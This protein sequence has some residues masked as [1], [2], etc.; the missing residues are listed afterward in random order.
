MRTRARSAR[1]Q[2]QAV[3]LLLVVFR[4]AKARGPLHTFAEQRA[5][6]SPRH[7]FAEQKATISFLSPHQAA[8]ESSDEQVLIERI[9]ARDPDALARY[10]ERHRDR[11]RRF[12]HSITA[13]RLRAVV[14]VDDL[15]QEVSA[16]AITG[17]PTAPLDRYEPLE[18]LQQL[19]RRR[20]IDAHRF[21]FGAQRRDAGRQRSIHGEGSGQGSDGGLEALIAASM[22]SPSA[23]VS[24]E[25]RLDRVEQAI[26]GLR[27]EQQAVI[28]MR[29]AEGMTT[30]AIAQKLGKT[31]VAVRVLLSRCMRQL[32]QQLDDVRPT[33]P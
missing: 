25:L 13:E 10:I 33:R 18:W 28:R 27:A 7:A 3:N 5:T 15:I 31:D 19:A 12:V 17:L 29:Y 26:Q 8:M 23:V 30:K 9:T 6:I 20:V 16:A 24:R 32:E 14:E 2:F 22:T 4:S 21:H 11:L 1:R